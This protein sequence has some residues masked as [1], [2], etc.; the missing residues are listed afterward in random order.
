[1]HT[2]IAKLSAC[3]SRFFTESDIVIA[4]GFSPASNL[5][6]GWYPGGPGAGDRHDYDLG[7]LDLVLLRHGESEWNAK[8]LFTGWVDVDL[9]PAGEAEART[10]G[11]LLAAEEDLDLRVLHTS[12]LTRAIR[13]AEI[14]LAAAGRSWLPV[15]RDWRLNE[16]HY[17][18][19]QGKNKAQ[20]K[21]E[22]GADQ[23]M[24][25]RRSYDTPPPPL[26]QDNPY[27]VSGDPRYR[28]LNPADLPRTE[29]L[30]DVVLRSVPYLESAIVPDLRRTAQRGGAV[31]VAAHG[32]SIRAL[33]KHLEG[34]ADDDITEL[35]VPT[36]IPYRL[37]LDDN[38]GVSSA[39][40]LGDPET[41]AAAAAAVAAQADRPTG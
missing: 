2:S 40:Y 12:V 14:A 23:L 36:G 34:I 11:E 7:V 37:R 18:D 28:D 29:C 16:R 24:A 21:Q 35:E 31:L 13:T 41:A 6:R 5:P 19:L 4:Q 38:L 32:N 8:N 22:F 1:M 17:G 27:D 25:W 3:V 26:A 39:G 15:R 10:G 20:I 30:A 9:T 33:R